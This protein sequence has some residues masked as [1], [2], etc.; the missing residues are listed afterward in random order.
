MDYINGFFKVSLYLWDN[1]YLFMMYF[2]GLE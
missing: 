2:Y 1:I